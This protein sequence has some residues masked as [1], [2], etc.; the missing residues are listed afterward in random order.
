MSSTDVLIYVD[1]YSNEQSIFSSQIGMKNFVIFN[2][3]SIFSSQI[4]MKNFFVSS[5]I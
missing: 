2:E 5:L 4:R 1:V 3:Q